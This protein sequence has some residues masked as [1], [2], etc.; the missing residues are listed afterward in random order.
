MPILEKQIVEYPEGL[1][2]DNFGEALSGGDEPVVDRQWWAVYTKARQ[3]KALARDL[4]GYGV[5]FYLPLLTQRK[6]YRGRFVQS[7]VPMFTGYLFLFVSDD[8][9]VC[10]LT[11]NRVSQF[12]KVKDQEELRRNLRQVRQ[13][14]D[15][16]LPL[17]PE[18]RLVP[19][20]RVRVKCGSLEGTE[21]VIDKRGGPGRCRLIV[22]VKFLQR[23][24]SLD[25]DECFLEPINDRS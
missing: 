18:S 4:V 25:I 16:K 21:G 6:P 14:I 24:V 20:S 15:S 22:E 23:G 5:P 12:I 10:S 7:H 9:R 13:A 3:E 11:T 17:T 2:D 19:G 8:E 1:L